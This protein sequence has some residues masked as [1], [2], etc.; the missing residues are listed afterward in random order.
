MATLFARDQCGYSQPTPLPFEVRQRTD[1]VDDDGETVTLVFD[2]CGG[3]C[4]TNL[5]MGLSLDFPEETS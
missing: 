3:E 2:L 1:E 4:L 5:A